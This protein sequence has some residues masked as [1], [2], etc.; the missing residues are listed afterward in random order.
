MCHNGLCR[1]TSIT[2]PVLTSTDIISCA[3]MLGLFISMSIEF[4]RHYPCLG[5]LSSLT[6]AL[7]FE[8]LVMGDVSMANLK[9]CLKFWS[10]LLAE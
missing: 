1:N 8:T 10:P 2:H 5:P 4:I 6:M 3:D 9:Y 7:V